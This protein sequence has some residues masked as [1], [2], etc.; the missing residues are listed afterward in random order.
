M[1]KPKCAS[2]GQF[3]CMQS[4]PTVAPPKFCPM[5][6]FPEIIK[7]SLQEY[8]DDPLKSSLATNSARI[9]AEGYL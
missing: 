5:E 7:E 9:E 1:N 2:C 3:N 4:A 6:N 8:K